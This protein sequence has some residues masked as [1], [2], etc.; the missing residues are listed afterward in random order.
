MVTSVVYIFYRVGA[1]RPSRS[2]TSKPY[3]QCCHDHIPRDPSFALLAAPIAA[4]HEN[5]PCPTQYTSWL[6]S[7]GN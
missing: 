5:V 6:E 1:C 2:V 3:S 7:F 4:K